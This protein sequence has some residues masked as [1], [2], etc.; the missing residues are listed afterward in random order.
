[1]NLTNLKYFCDVVRAGSFIEAARINHV[2]QP[3][4]SQGIKKLEQELEIYLLEH[5]RN[6]I[7]TTSDGKKVYKIAEDLFASEERY[8]RGI[9]NIK[10]GFVNNLTIA[11]S[12]SLLPLV[13]APAIKRFRKINPK[14]NVSIKIGKT[15]DQL[16][17]MNDDLIDVGICIDD[18][19][20]DDFEKFTICEGHFSL[21]GHPDSP[22]RILLT[23]PR[24]ETAQFLKSYSEKAKISDSLVIESWSNIYH[25]AKNMFGKGL[26]PDFMF[27]KN[28]FRNFSVSMKL[29]MPKY[30]VVAFFNQTQSKPLVSLLDE[31]KL[32]SAGRR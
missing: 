2:S 23:E 12:S 18:G 20:L 29:K 8:R 24:P 16:K 32:S 5:R 17:L 10:Q 3:A 27:N 30:R 13:L 6:S 14:V 21:V 22:D 15:S 25:L 19:T 9:E 11:V 26:L 1:M 4:I 28:E 7:N 31:L